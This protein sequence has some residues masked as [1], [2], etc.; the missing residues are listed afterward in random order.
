LYVQN[1]FVGAPTKTM[2]QANSTLSKLQE[3]TY[4]KMIMEDKADEFDKFVNSWN[5]LGGEQITKEVN[6]WYDSIK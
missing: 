1:K 3:E 5:K 2:V 4:I 6:E